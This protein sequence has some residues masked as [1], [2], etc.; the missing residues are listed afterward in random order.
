MSVWVLYTALI[1]QGLPNV[2]HIP[3]ESFPSKLTCNH[4]QAV[5]SNTHAVGNALPGDGRRIIAA[6]SWCMEFT[7][8]EGNK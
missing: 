2:A 7:G 3:V 6:Q 4:A 8:T 1:L 5:F